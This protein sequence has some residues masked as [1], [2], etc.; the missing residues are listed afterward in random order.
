MD[1]KMY[2]LHAR[3]RRLEELVERILKHLEV[4]EYDLPELENEE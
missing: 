2:E 4:D 3:I 1:G